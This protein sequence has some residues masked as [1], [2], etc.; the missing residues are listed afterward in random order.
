[1]D[2]DIQT[3]GFGFPS[4]D[5]SVVYDPPCPNIEDPAVVPL[6]CSHAIEISDCCESSGGVC[7]SFV[8]IVKLIDSKSLANIARS[9]RG[10][11]LVP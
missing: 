7:L 1:M 5:R 2:I 6:I 9:H 3:C 10:T 8:S 4:L 11:I